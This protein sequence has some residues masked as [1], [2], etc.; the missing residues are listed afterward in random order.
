MPDTPSAVARCVLPVPVPPILGDRAHRLLFLH[1]FDRQLLEFGRV[2]LLRYLH[3]LPLQCN[4]DFTSPLED[5]ISGEA[6][7]VHSIIYPEKTP[8]Y[9]GE[10]AGV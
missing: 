10:T 2:F 7:G 9:A 5:E 8:G 3:R 6:Q 1:A 4:C